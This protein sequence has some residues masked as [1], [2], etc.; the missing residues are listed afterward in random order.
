MKKITIQIS[1]KRLKHLRLI[2]EPVKFK[3]DAKMIEAELKNS[4]IELGYH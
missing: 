1:E 2:W 4:T 3:D